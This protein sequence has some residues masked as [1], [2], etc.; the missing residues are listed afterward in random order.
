MSK[1]AT[2]CFIR[3]R[4]EQGRLVSYCNDYYDEDGNWCSTAYAGNLESAQFNLEQFKK[5][6]KAD[7]GQKQKTGKT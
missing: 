7:Q 5:Q 6:I 3:P 4:F 1:Q 2:Q